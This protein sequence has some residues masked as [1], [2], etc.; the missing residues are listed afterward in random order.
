MNIGVGFIMK[1]ELRYMRYNKREGRITSTIKYLAV[2]VHDVAEKKK[3]PVIFKYGKKREVSDSS[4][5]Y[6]CG[7][8][9]VGQ[10]VDESI[11]DLHK[12]GQSKF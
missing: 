7:K 6:R 5:S 1:S 8:E 10:E 12:R 11:Y 9:E 2:C 4:L 3:F